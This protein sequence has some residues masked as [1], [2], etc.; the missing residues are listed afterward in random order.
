M[1]HKQNKQGTQAT[2]PLGLVVIFIIPGVARHA[3]NP[4]LRDGSPLGFIQHLFH[5]EKINTIP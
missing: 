1:A 4:G 5:F 2:T 3:R